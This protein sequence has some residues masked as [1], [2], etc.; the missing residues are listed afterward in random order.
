MYC[1]KFLCTIMVLDHAHLHDIKLILGTSCDENYVICINGHLKK[2]EEQ[3]TN[4]RKLRG[5][6]KKRGH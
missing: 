5:S 2:K 4:L 3:L 1:N 6:E